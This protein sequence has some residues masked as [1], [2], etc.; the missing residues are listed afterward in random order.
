[1]PSVLLLLTLILGFLARAFGG[2]LLSL[3]FASL[4]VGFNPSGNLL[5]LE[6]FRGLNALRDLLADWANQFLKLGAGVGDDS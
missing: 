4:A 3:L 5:T 1:M 2:L 6:L